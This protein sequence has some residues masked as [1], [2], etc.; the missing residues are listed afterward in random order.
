MGPGKYAG[1]CLVHPRTGHTVTSCRTSTV[2]AG[3]RDRDVALWCA[4]PGAERGAEVTGSRRVL[5]GILVALTVV[6]A[7]AAGLLF[8]RGVTRDAGDAAV[9]VSAPDLD[10][11]LIAF[12]VPPPSGTVAQVG[13]ERFR[14]PAVGLDVALGSVTMVDGVLTPP[15]FTAVYLVD[16]MGGTLESAAD[17]TLFAATHSVVGGRAPGNA[18]V[19][20]ETGTLLVSPGDVIVVDTLRY[21][22]ETS[23]V[24][25]KSEVPADEQLWADEPGRLVLITCLQKPDGSPSES[26]LV[27]T[28]ALMP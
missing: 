3:G 6:A 28:G 8:V 25:P 15:G 9:A 24:I 14:V 2:G 17:H 12:D 10:G 1:E 26:N 18:L 19:E 22:L 7:I 16:G 20:T 5:I 23:Q 11:T 27:V 21:R 4:S 13:T